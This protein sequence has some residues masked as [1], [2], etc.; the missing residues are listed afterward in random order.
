MMMSQ[1]Y[2]PHKVKICLPVLSLRKVDML[3]TIVPSGRTLYPFVY[4]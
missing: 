2:F 4:Q 1:L 3:S